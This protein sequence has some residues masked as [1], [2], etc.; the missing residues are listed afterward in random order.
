MAQVNGLSTGANQVIAEAQKINQDQAFIAQNK[1][2]PTALAGR[3]DEF[4]ADYKNFQKDSAGLQQSSDISDV[5]VAQTAEAGVSDAFGDAQAGLKEAMGGSD[6]QAALSAGDPT[7]S[8][9]QSGTEALID[10]GNANTLHL[11]QLNNNLDSINAQ[12]G[13]AAKGAPLTPSYTLQGNGGDFSTQQQYGDSAGHG[14][15]A[16]GTA[17]PVDVAQ[18]ADSIRSASGQQSDSTHYISNDGT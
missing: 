7:I 4:Q 5:A 3:I 16:G 2:N 9:L 10:E 18:I 11:Q 14:V 1:N 8:H 12:T 6:A 17:S 15:V 13:A